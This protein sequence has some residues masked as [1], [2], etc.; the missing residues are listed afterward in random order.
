MNLTRKIVCLTLLVMSIATPVHS[1]FLRDGFLY[2]SERETMR[3]G[4]ETPIWFTPGHYAGS[5]H[6]NDRFNFRY[7][8]VEIEGYLT[9]SYYPRFY[10][11]V[12]ID[13]LQFGQYLVARVRIPS[14]LDR[15]WYIRNN[16]IPWVDGHN[17][18]YMTRIFLRGYRGVHIFQRRTGVGAGDTLIM[19][20]GVPQWQAIFVDGDVEVHGVFAGALT[21]G[22]SGDMW[23]I[24]NVRYEGADRR[25]GWFE[26]DWMNHMLGLV[27][28]GDIIIKNDTLNG[29]GDGWNQAR[30]D[31]NRHSIVINAMLCALGG[32]FRFEHTNEDWDAYRGPEPDERGIVHLR[33]AL[34]Q[35][36]GFSLYNSNNDG[37]G[38]R[39]DYSFDERLN[40]RPPPFIPDRI[41][42]IIGNSYDY[43]D[44]PWGNGSQVIGDVE[45]RGLWGYGRARLHF[46][47]AY[48]V[49]V[50]DRLWLH[51]YHDEPIHLSR[52]YSEAG[53][54]P[55]LLA[56][57]GGV[58]PV[59]D[60]RNVVFEK[61][62]R[63]ELEADTILIDS[64]RFD[65]DVVLRGE[66]VDVR[67]SHFTARVRLDGWGEIAFAR[68]LVEGALVVDGN[69]YICE[70]TNN[71]I[72]NPDGDGVRL[73]TYRRLEMRSNIVAFS[74]RGVVCDHWRDPVLA[75]ND[76]YGN[77][78]G[79]YIDCL[80]DTGSISAHP[81]FVD[82]ENGNYSL[83][84]NSSCID[85]GDPDSPLDPDGSRA[86][87]GAF[88]YDHELYVP[89][90]EQIAG[91]FTLTASPNPFNYQVDLRLSVYH[92][93]SAV[94]AVHDV[95]GRHI[96][97]YNQAVMPGSNALKLTGESLQVPGV[98]FVTVEFEESAK[99]LKLVYLP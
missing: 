32:S 58:M 39:A 13:D 35:R 98:Y 19:T 55:A 8:P 51:G 69:P 31:I 89:D 16:A 68:N 78:D 86:D 40:R 70:L 43:I 71:T 28:E 14:P 10:E 18:Q 1:Q 60:L 29:R 20:L 53:V 88:S 67:N 23:L 66:Y 92:R 22:C 93:G 96:V 73:E 99:V 25:T 62:V 63:V 2:F 34:M 91:E 44:I 79:N 33:G 6:T 7:L 5:I 3:D 49:L 76:V 45:C 83:A 56:M 59:A 64:C 75:Y 30:G 4:D 36:V 61:G 97:S 37:T 15:E 81:R 72:V 65:D 21:I 52:Q 46:L 85:T 27:S 80:P 12:S 17:G 90:R 26:E 57:R 50:R 84:W 95:R 74:R 77:G 9:C 87:M 24:D 54:A 48:T 82:P 11:G 41:H 38:Y 94:V 42:F 47:G